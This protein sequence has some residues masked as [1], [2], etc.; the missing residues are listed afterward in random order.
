ME[1]KTGETLDP[2]STM[3]A[4][5]IGP[6]LHLSQAAIKPGQAGYLIV[7]SR[8]RVP[9]RVR[10]VKITCRYRADWFVVSRIFRKTCTSF[11]AV[12]GLSGV[13]GCKSSGTC[14]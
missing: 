7:E 8:R 9:F 11:F 5:Q 12:E 13:N 14:T 4:R 2:T 3:T 1:I 6:V 10:Q